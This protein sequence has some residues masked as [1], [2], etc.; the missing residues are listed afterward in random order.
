MRTQKGKTKRSDQVDSLKQKRPTSLACWL[1]GK[2]TGLKMSPGVPRRA[3][4]GGWAEGILGRSQ[5]FPQVPGV[6]VFLVWWGA[7]IFNP[8][9]AELS[10]ADLRT[11]QDFLLDIYQYGW[12]STSWMASYKAPFVIAGLAPLAVNCLLA[13][14]VCFFGHP[15]ASLLAITDCHDWLDIFVAERE[16]NMEGVF[17]QATLKWLSSQLTPCF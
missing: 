14:S 9:K 7:C 8:L 11:A 16:N 12:D 3:R 2:P 4:G 15:K 10:A 6:F 5:R 17:C 1:R 13:S